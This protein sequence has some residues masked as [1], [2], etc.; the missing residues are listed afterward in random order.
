MMSQPGE[1]DSLDSGPFPCPSRVQGSRVFEVSARLLWTALET[2][3]LN[4]ETAE[5]GLA[6]KGSGKDSKDKTL[7]IT[8]T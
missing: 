8:A 3:L 5:A 1:N 7:R 2:S 4:F 6:V